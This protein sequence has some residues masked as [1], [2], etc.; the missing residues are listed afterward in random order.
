MNRKLPGIE[1]GKP[2]PLPD[3]EI[4]VCPLCR[5]RDVAIESYKNMAYPFYRCLGCQ[6]GFY[7]SV[8]LSLCNNPRKH[9]RFVSRKDCQKCSLKVGGFSA[10]VPC[11]HWG[12]LITPPKEIREAIR[13]KKR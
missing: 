6:A 1:I 10:G 5:S 12:G 2:L 8:L 7:K 11:L 4:L 13:A 9:E 3:M